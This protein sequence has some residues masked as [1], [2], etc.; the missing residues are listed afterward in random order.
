MRNYI[1][2][3]DYPRGNMEIIAVALA[4]LGPLTIWCV[5]E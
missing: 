1:L 5:F 4:L 3:F 2:L